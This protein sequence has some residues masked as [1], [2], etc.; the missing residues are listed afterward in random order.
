MAKTSCGYAAPV[1]STVTGGARFLCA[2]GSASAAFCVP[3][4]L[5]VRRQEKIFDSRMHWQ[6]QWHTRARKSVPPANRKK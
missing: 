4:A 2:T 5:P 6:S 1:A 3:L